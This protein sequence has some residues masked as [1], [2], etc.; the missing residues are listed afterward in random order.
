MVAR[1]IIRDWTLA[2]GTATVGSYEH[3]NAWGLYDM[4]GNVL[5]WCRDWNFSESYETG[6]DGNPIKDP[7]G[8]PY[9]NDPA[10]YNDSRAVRG[11]GWCSPASG[12]R[13]AYRGTSYYC[14]TETDHGFRIVCLTV[15]DPI[16]AEQLTPRAR[17]Y[18]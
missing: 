2:K 7:V 14:A 5:E 6:T 17:M 16:S 10:A 13:S 3:P 11:G 12:C 18:I 4:H 9:H 15:P 8:A 1:M